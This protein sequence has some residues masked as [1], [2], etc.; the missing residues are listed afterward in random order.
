MITRAWKLPVYRMYHACNNDDAAE[1]PVPDTMPDCCAIVQHGFWTRGRRDKY[2]SN[3]SRQDWYYLSIT[4][5]KSPF[6]AKQTG[7]A[8]G[9]DI[10]LYFFKNTTMSS[11][12]MC[13]WAGKLAACTWQPSETFS[14]RQPLFLPSKHF[15]NPFF[16][17]QNSSRPHF[18]I[19]NLAK[20]HIFFFVV[21]Q[22]PNL[23]TA[24]FP[25][26]LCTLCSTV[27]V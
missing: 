1:N 24:L 8:L 12:T 5:N 16:F 15:K 2:L 19:Q 4:Y 17:L 23:T 7:S 22:K 9:V 11:L 26:P 21:L 10:E 27:S 20:H 18:S 6:Q 25:N 13:I 3:L 14:K